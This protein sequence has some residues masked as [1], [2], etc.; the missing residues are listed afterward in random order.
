[1][2][3]PKEIVCKLKEKAGDEYV[4]VNLYKYVRFAD[5]QLIDLTPFEWAAVFGLFEVTVTSY[6]HGTL[7]SL[8]NY[9]P[10]VNYDFNK[11]SQNNEG[12]ICDVMRKMELSECHFK[13]RKDYDDIVDRVFNVIE[14]RESYVLKIKKNVEKLSESSEAFFDKVGELLK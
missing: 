11:F 9:T 5:K 10:V 13:E 6:F 4:L 1:M 12:K 3:A 2:G 7:L 14:D 8:R